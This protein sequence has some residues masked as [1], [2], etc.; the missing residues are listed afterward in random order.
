MTIA[1]ERSTVIP[2]VSL[3]DE[4]LV[5][6]ENSTGRQSVDKFALQL[7]SSSAIGSLSDAKQLYPTRADLP[8]AS[9]LALRFSAVVFADPDGNN[10][11]TWSVQLDNLGAKTWLWSLPL[12]FSVIRATDAGAGTANAIQAS[13]NVPV[14]DGILTA[15]RPFR[16]SGAGAAT[17]SFNGDDPLTIRDAGGSVVVAA[18]GIKEGLTI[19]G[20]RSGT[21]FDLI[22][23]I[24]A[25]ASAA[26]AAASAELADTTASS[27]LSTLE[28]A[29]TIAVNEATESADQSAIDADEAREL[30]EKFATNPEDAVVT[31]GLFSAFHWAQKAEAT[32]LAGLA[33]GSV[34]IAKLAADV[35]NLL[36]SKVAFLASGTA[37]PSLNIGPI[38]HADYNAFMTWQTFSANGASYTGYASAEIGM[39]RLD[40]QASPRAGWLKRNGGSYSK[41][42]Y[43]PLWNW[44]L[45]NGC[46]VTLGSWAAGAFVFADN[47]DGTF[48]LPDNRGEFERIWDDGRG[49]DS[50][51]TSGSHQLDQLQG[52]YHQSARGDNTAANGQYTV[53]PNATGSFST[54]LVRGAISDGT[55]GTPRI[56]AETRSRS[57]ALPGT[58]KF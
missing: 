36:A 7:L 23:D 35:A 43:A 54:L 26:S 12:Q 22:T 8:A 5:N 18:S 11:G 1:G 24:D 17:V 30:A 50:G 45:H 31:G 33:D 10:N 20:F 39:P 38:W 47:G 34:T 46:V 19:A 27:F 58:I 29:L 51:R 28:A 56:G 14:A 41:T 52:H 37:L 55:N 9:G 2:S 44:A 13:S 3:A 53:G 49:I 42:T 48:K 6:R 57:V 16:D 21:Y 32:V 25:A 15:F 40:G 4:I